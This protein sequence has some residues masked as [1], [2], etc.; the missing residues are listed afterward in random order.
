VPVELPGDDGISGVVGRWHSPGDAIAHSRI[1]ETQ[2]K[3]VTRIL[4]DRYVTEIFLPAA[5]LNGFDPAH[6][7]QLAFNIHVRNYQHATEYY[8]SAPKQV[9]TQ[10][11]PQTWGALYLSRPSQSP[12]DNGGQLPVA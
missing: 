10:A 6:H 9:L 7:P 12:R 5:A 11:R 1:P 4:S 2:V 3:S 8:W